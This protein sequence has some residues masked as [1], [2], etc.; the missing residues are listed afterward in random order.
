MVLSRFF[1]LAILFCLLVLPFYI[2]NLIW[3]TQSSVTAG[4]AA[5]RG[6]ETSGQIGHLYTVICFTVK[7]DTVFFNSG[8]NIFLEPGTPVSVRYNKGDYKDARINTTAGVWAGTIIYSLMPLL[9]IV[10]IAVHK[11]L[12]PYHAKIKIGGKNYIEIQSRE[13]FSSHAR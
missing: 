7:N 13:Q 5:F 6:K 2:V 8:D 3:L 11:T 12:I 9:I 10:I 1:F 4:T